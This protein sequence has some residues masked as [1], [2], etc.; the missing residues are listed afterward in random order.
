MTPE[1]FARGLTWEQYVA[2]TGSPANLAREGFD[3]RRFSLMKPRLDWSAY[4][5][6]RHTRARLTDEQAAAIRWLAGQPGGPATVA[7]IA[8]DWSSD[9]RRD[10]PFLARLAE[11]G[12]LEL[13]IFVRD[14]EVM[15]RK[16]LPDPA[17]GDNADLVVAYA[18]EK[19]GERFATVPVAVF[20]DASFGELHRYIE[21]PAIYRMDRLL[22]HLRAARAGETEE[23]TKARGGRDIGT[24]LESPFFDVWAQAAIAE[25]ISALHE[26]LLTSTR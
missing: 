15:L 11:A 5:R 14:G 4:L 8:E 25:I 2:F 24:L 22:G 26:R 16:G 9:C 7:V 23:Q 21:Y 1:R 18:N 20:F 19:N 3:V 6:E 10:L 12:G 17:A 13:R